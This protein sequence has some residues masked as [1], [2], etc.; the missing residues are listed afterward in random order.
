MAQHEVFLTGGTGFL[1]RSLA[2]ELMRRGHRVRALA[3]PG[4]E[5]RI[6][7]GCEVVHGDALRAETYAA[8]IGAAD[9]FVHLVGVAHPSPNKAAEFRAIDLPSCREAVRAAE[10]AGVRHIVYL[11][12]ARPAPMMREFQAVRAEGERMVIESGIPASFVRPWY[13]L[14]PGRQWPIVLKP[15]YALARAYPPTRESAIRLALVTLEQM[16]Q[17]LAW[18]VEN[19]PERLQIFD[20]PQIKAGGPCETSRETTMA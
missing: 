7:R 11:S 1:G 15:F 19:P 4:S 5:S 8:K 2:A 9:T 13:V 14:G 20:P 12:V 6:V 3:R 16:T 18:A 10:Q 17:T